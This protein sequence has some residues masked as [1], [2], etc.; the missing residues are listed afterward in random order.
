MFLHRSPGAQKR[1]AEK[2]RIPPL[3]PHT[4]T[5]TYT[6]LTNA[7]I[8]GGLLSRVWKN[9]LLMIRYGLTRAANVGSSMLSGSPSMYRFVDAVSCSCS[10]RALNE[11]AGARAPADSSAP[12]PAPAL[13]PAVAAVAVEY[14]V[15]GILWICCADAR[16]S[17]ARVRRGQAKV[18]RRTLENEGCRLRYFRSVSMHRSAASTVSNLRNDA[19]NSQPD[20]FTGRDDAATHR[21]KPYPL[22]DATEEEE[23]NSSAFPF[24]D[25]RP[26]INNEPNQHLTRTK[27]RSPLKKTSKK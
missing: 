6:H 20:G 11:S 17:S 9:R 27:T 16:A 8:L 23:K 4:H 10:I 12:V 24:T 13:A 22:H 18:G 21:T 5:H 14:T 19:C 25:D 15:P 2:V 26:Q 3:I 7:I 1:V